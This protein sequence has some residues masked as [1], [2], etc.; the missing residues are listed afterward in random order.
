MH[1]NLKNIYT[2]P[3]SWWPKDKKPAQIILSKM[4]NLLGQIIGKV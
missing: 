4:G 2:S 1:Q 3:E